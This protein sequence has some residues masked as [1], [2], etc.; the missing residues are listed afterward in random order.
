MPTIDTRDK[1]LTSSLKL[2]S[3][4]GYIGATTRE[5][6][7]EACVAEVT[8]FRYFES[9][10]K[11]F[12]DVLNHYS[13]L[14][15]LEVIIKE[16]KDMPYEEGINII[17]LKFYDALKSR[18]DIIR[19]IQTEMHR[20]PDKIANLYHSMIDNIIITLANYFLEL[21]NAGTLKIFDIHHAARGLMGLI[22]SVFNTQELML[23][24][25]YR[26]DVDTDIIKSLVNIFVRGTMR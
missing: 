17:A 6:A 12:E 1:I 4:K 7:K 18:K 11:L 9:K 21:Q 2:F 8:L 20:Y 16:I 24:S 5:I 13:F 22:F 25:K 14:P 19:I 15:E 26:N 23:R 3:E 10:E